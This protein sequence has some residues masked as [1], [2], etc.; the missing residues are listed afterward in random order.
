M[1]H[2][3]DGGHS[4]ATGEDSER[5]FLKADA[6]ANARVAKHAPG[7]DLPNLPQVMALGG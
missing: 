1:D 7:L 6:R 3:I 2:I 4:I 5:D